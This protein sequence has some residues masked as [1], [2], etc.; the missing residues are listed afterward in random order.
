MKLIKKH[1]NKQPA[2]EKLLDIPVSSYKNTFTEQFIQIT[3]EWFTKQ[4]NKINEKLPTGFIGYEVTGFLTEDEINNLIGN[5][6]FDDKASIKN[7]IVQLKN[8]I[9]EAGKNF[10]KSETVLSH[11]KVYK[12]LLLY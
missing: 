3:D 4:L 5:G 10:L 8:L 2:M 9:H 11:F 1:F 7:V 12:D 6:H